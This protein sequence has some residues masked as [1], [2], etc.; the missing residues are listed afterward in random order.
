MKLY[1]VELHNLYSSLNIIRQ[2]ESWRMRL[3]EHVARMGEMRKVY[4]VLLG[5][6]ERKRPLGR[7]R[8]RWENG[9]RMDL[10]EIDWVGVN[11]IQLTQDKS[12]GGLL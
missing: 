7:P 6:T 8:R 10:R 9:I 5:K 3:A 11:W 12:C 4:K 2:I 1:S